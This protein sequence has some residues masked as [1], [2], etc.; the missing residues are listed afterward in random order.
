VGRGTRVRVFNALTVSELFSLV[1][2]PGFHGVLRLAQGDVNHDGVLDV[3]VG[4]GPGGRGRVRVI[5]GRTRG[6]LAGFRPFPALFRRDVVVA[7]ADVNGDGFAD[8]FVLTAK[9][10]GVL[11]GRVFDGKGLVIGQV[12]LLETVVLRP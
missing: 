12:K 10:D 7:A 8:V 4:T 9:R 5:N 11:R 1:P 3:I 6:L 2:L